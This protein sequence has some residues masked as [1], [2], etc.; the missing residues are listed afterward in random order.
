MKINKIS[1]TLLLILLGGLVVS[2]IIIFKLFGTSPISFVIIFF[3]VLVTGIN[4][5]ILYSKA[6]YTLTEI[7]EGKDDI[8]FRYTYKNEPQT[9]TVRY[10]DLDFCFK[11]IKGGVIFVL[12]EQKQLKLKLFSYV[13][14]HQQKFVQL[15]QI[16]RN[17]MPSE[18][19]RETKIIDMFKKIKMPYIYTKDYTQFF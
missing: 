8:T 4:L 14:D 18:R 3:F 12:W 6:K 7:I 17:N 15:N 9:I 13:A 10:S 2:S 19:I 11:H 5:L 16:L 1:P